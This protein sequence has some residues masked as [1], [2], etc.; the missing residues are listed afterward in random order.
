[1]MQKSQLGQLSYCLNS[2]ILV[3]PGRPLDP[4]EAYAMNVVQERDLAGQELT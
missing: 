3:R 1:M 2:R 4:S